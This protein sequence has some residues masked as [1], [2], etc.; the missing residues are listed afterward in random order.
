MSNM[1]NLKCVVC[2]E[3]MEGLDKSDNVCFGCAFRIWKNVND[4]IVSDMAIGFKKPIYHATA[5]KKIV[6]KNGKSKTKH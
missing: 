1:A 6:K 4:F 5:I 3:K 2:K